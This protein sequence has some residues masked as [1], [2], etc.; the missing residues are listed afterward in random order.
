MGICQMDGVHEKPT[1][2]NA[3]WKE[4]DFCCYFCFHSLEKMNG[5]VNQNRIENE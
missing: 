3:K 2:I 1:Q 4:S 5:C